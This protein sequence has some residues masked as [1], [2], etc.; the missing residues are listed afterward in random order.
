[1]ASMIFYAHASDEAR[2]ELF[3]IVSENR[4]LALRWRKSRRLRGFGFSN[5]A[6]MLPVMM[7]S[8][9]R[10]KRRGKMRDVKQLVTPEHLD[11]C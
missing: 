3:Q 2:R 7:R 1:M 8:G 11:G 9:P 5:V 4:H 10:P 6:A